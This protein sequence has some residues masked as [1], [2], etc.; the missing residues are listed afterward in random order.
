MVPDQPLIIE[1]RSLKVR[2]W[3]ANRKTLLVLSFTGFGPTTVIGQIEIPQRS[4]LLPY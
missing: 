4:S 1:T 2:F 3:G